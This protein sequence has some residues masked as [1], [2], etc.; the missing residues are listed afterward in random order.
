M[1]DRQKLKKDFGIDECEV[2]DLKR[3]IM[4]KL[5]YALFNNT[6]LFSVCKLDRYAV[7]Y[8]ELEDAIVKKRGVKSIR[9]IT[10][11]DA[12]DVV[13]SSNPEFIVAANELNREGLI[14]PVQNDSDYGLRLTELGY[15]YI[16]RN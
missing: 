11:Y 2:V 13:K 15:G 1:L 10:D 8:S 4:D 6:P 5:A 12:D 3:E 14:T 9:R 7:S 16:S